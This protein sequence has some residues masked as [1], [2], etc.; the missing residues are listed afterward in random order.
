MGKLAV[1]V[2]AIALR[3]G[4]ANARFTKIGHIL[5]LL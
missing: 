2:A 5:Q 1:E 3:E 4:S